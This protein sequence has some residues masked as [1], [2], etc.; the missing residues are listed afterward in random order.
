MLRMLF[1]T[2]EKEFQAAKKIWKGISAVVM[3]PIANEDDK[4]AYLAIQKPFIEVMLLLK[5]AYTKN[6]SEATRCYAGLSFMR[7]MQK[8]P[9]YK[10]DPSFENTRDFFMEQRKNLQM[11]RALLDGRVVD[12]FSRFIIYGSLLFD[13]EAHARQIITDLEK[14]KTPGFFMTTAIIISKELNYDMARIKQAF[15]EIDK[16]PDN[17]AIILYMMQSEELLNRLKSCT[18]DDA[19][20]IYKQYHL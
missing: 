13:V 18:L 7:V 10:A 4:K 12:D 3:K 1:G 15:S 6:H 19:K 20:K 17:D 16:R 2:G 9:L 8:A 14:Q 11:V 5:A